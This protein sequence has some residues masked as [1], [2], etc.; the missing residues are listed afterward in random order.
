MSASDLE[1]FFPCPSVVPVGL[2]P[3]QPPSVEPAV[4]YIQTEAESPR[5]TS[6]GLDQFSEWDT[7][8]VYTEEVQDLSCAPSPP[9]VTAVP[10]WGEVVEETPPARQNHAWCQNVSLNL[11]WD[12]PISTLQKQM[13]RKYHQQEKRGKHHQLNRSKTFP[14]ASRSLLVL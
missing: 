2:K 9:A 12:C 1:N 7:E 8:E 5:S 10:L 4:E 14:W 11:G 3:S 6:A 13:Q